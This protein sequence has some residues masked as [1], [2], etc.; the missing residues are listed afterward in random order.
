MAE[1]CLLGTGGMLPLKDRFLTSL[2]AEY[3]GKAILIDCGEGTQ[4]AMVKHGLKMSRIEM[5]LITHAHADHVTGLPGLLLSIGNCSRTLPLEIYFPESCRSTIE[6]LMSVCGHLPYE[7]VLH[8]LPEH[9]PVSFKAE[10]IDPM[11]TVTTV[12]LRHS[13]DCIGYSLELTRKPVFEPEKAKSLEVPV[14]YWK[15]LHAG[16]TVE[17]DDGR[18]ITP[19]A[20]TGEKRP[21]LKVTYTTDSLP[22]DSI[23]E[24]AKGA[25]LFICE[26]MYGTPDKKQSMNEKGHMLMQDACEIAAEAGVKR[27]WLTHYSPAEKDP[28]Q[29]AEELKE[30][31]PETE[32]PDDGIKITL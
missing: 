29:Y 13:V 21:P 18:R 9:E 16:E 32:V 14:E 1:I 2:Y 10:S 30:I 3:G 27:L 20:V 26:G 15:K 8:G 11:L 31:F 28:V 4:V 19:D 5:L 24:A 25:D 22:I 23:S 17:L 6:S 12:P 7:T